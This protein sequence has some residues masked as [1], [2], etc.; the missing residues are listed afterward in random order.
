MR[1][2]RGSR[3]RGQIHLFAMRVIGRT[4]PAKRLAKMHWCWTIRTGGHLSEIDAHNFGLT[5]AGLDQT[6]LRVCLIGQ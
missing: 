2:L 3:A 1:V 5:G 4:R 6:Q